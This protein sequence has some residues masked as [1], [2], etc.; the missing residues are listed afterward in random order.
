[1]KTILI[2]AFSLIALINCSH[3]RADS[4][5]IML[6]SE[7]G[8]RS[9]P[10]VGNRGY[11]HI[12]YGYKLHKDTGLD[13]DS[14]SIEI[15]E[16][17]ASLMLDTKVEKIESKLSHGRYGKTFKRQ[18][19]ARKDVLISMA[20]QMGYSGLMSFTNM[21]SALEADNMAKAA[22]EALDSLWAIQTPERAQRHALT[23][24]IGIPHEY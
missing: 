9:A 13:P 6:K 7:E 11:V 14:F 23:L 2:L 15:S 4:T 3:V 18:T 8:F 1:M 22:I 16:K 19:Q 24:L 12:G 10:Y 5:S 20:Y 21:W 17:V